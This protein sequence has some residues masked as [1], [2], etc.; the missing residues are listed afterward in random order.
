MKC[1][2]E[3]FICNRKYKNQISNLPV[4]KICEIQLDF[5]PMEDKMKFRVYQGGIFELYAWDEEYKQRT[6][7]VINSEEIIKFLDYLKIMYPSINNEELIASVKRYNLKPDIHFLYEN[8]SLLDDKTKKILTKLCNGVFNSTILKLF[9]IKICYH[10]VCRQLGYFFLWHLMAHEANIANGGYYHTLRDLTKLL[11][12]RFKLITVNKTPENILEY[13]LSYLNDFLKEKKIKLTS[14][15]IARLNLEAKIIKEKRLLLY[16]FFLLY[17]KANMRRDTGF[18]TGKI[19]PVFSPSRGAISTFFI[20]YVL[21]ISYF[22]PMNYGIEADASLFSDNIIAEIGVDS[23]NKNI[24]NSD[25]IKCSPQDVLLKHKRIL[26]RIRKPRCFLSEI[27]LS[28][29]KTLRVF[30][31]AETKDVFN[32]DNDEIRQQLRKKKVKSFNDIVKI[33]SLCCDSIVQFESIKKIDIL[34]N[35]LLSWRDAYFKAH[36]PNEFVET[37]KDMSR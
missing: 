6:S 29:K 3:Y 33:Y 19:D 9:G 10:F 20:A 12:D 26:G 27:S 21:E 14:E 5:L 37:V 36:Y 2:F 1:F 34:N 13:P 22:N 18:L 35:T 28:D 23:E 16:V 15:I 32:F 31:K 24:L 30:Q 8:F 25:V 11:S 7:I 17:E 4:T